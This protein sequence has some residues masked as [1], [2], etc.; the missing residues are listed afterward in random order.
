MGVIGMAGAGLVVMM[1]G[2]WVIHLR[3][4]NAAIVDVGW[5]L[6]LPILACCYATR[7]EPGPRGWILA[8][9]VI[10]WGVRLA[11][12]LFVTRVIGHEED[13]RYVELRRGWGDRASLYFFVFFQAQVLLDL[14]LSLPLWLVMR[15]RAPLGFVEP[16]AIGLWAVA[17]AGEAIADRQLA[18][19][20]RSA[21]APGAV[22]DRGLW[23][24]SRHPNYF[25]EWLIWVAYAL[26]ASTASW[27]WLAWTAPALMLFFLFRVTGIPATEAQALRSRGDA[28]RRYQRTTSVFVPWR[29]TRG[30]E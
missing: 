27:G 5:A 4:R 2:F 29:R 11:A 28:Y 13:G 10:V 3:M 20:R 19:F 21:H 22:C 16:I 17:L 18:A 1:T 24:Y 6:G 26:Y 30:A 14:L 9:L 8:A 7:L 23:A 15:E 25:F 12:Y